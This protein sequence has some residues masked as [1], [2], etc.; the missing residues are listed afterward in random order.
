MPGM[1][2]L[3][4]APKQG[5]EKVVKSLVKETT[6]LF[7]G[8]TKDFFNPEDVISQK[9]DWVSRNS[10][11]S[12]LS[13]NRT[14]SKD[15][16]ITCAD[17]EDESSSA[18]ST[19]LALP[20]FDYFCVVGL[21]DRPETVDFVWSETSAGSTRSRSECVCHS[22]TVLHSYPPGALPDDLQR[23]I[24]SYCF[25]MGTGAYAVERSSELGEITDVVYG[26][27]YDLRS[28]A[29]F[30]FQLQTTTPDKPTPEILFG[31]CFYRK[32]FL[33]RPPRT[34]LARN[35]VNDQVEKEF[36]AI[37]DRLVA[38][39]RCY[40]MLSRV[41]LF[42]SHFELLRKILSFE[43]HFQIEE[44]AKQVD[45]GLWSLD[46][47]DHMAESASL[48]LSHD[49]QR[50]FHRR[51]VTIVGDISSSDSDDE[52]PS[53]SGKS[54]GSIASRSEKKKGTIEDDFHTPEDTPSVPLLVDDLNDTTPFF[55]AREKVKN[56]S[57]KTKRTLSRLEYSRNR[58]T[59]EDI[60]IV[61]RNLTMLVVERD[62][63]DVSTDVRK[64]TDQAS[65]EPSNSLELGSWIEADGD[66]LNLTGYLDDTATSRTPKQDPM[67]S[68]PF[69]QVWG[70]QHPL[71]LLERYK[72][73]DHT[74]Y[75]SENKELSSKEILVSASNLINA[76]GEHVLS[77][78]CTFMADIDFLAARELEG[79]AICVLCRALS[80]EN[81]VTYLTA[82]LLE[83]QIVVFESNIAYLSAIVLSILPL[84]I[85]FSWQSL[86][87]PIV[88]L[89]KQD[90]LEAPVPFV[91]GMLTKTWDIRAKCGNLVRVNAY[92]D[93]VKNA[94]F[95]KLPN[96]H[97]LIK[98]LEEPHSKI[99]R[100]GMQYGA[101]AQPIY[102]ISP[103]ERDLATSFASTVRHHLMSLTSDMAGYMITDVGQGGSS[104]NQACSVLMRETFV[105]SFDDGHKPFVD[106]WTQTQ[107]FDAYADWISYN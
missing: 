98:S 29:S 32:E 28:D 96:A 101:D 95:P 67:D 86:L 36:G 102:E 87:L 106:E 21:E 81:I 54:E 84:L 2:K 99:R 9:R 59:D 91:I 19:A 44:Y 22:S 64:D 11:F 27:H 46:R 13:N 69:N 4:T 72:K 82:V 65:G 68:A 38:S 62:R 78:K 70:N 24:P 37:P 79:W 26:Q 103:E 75:W 33:H 43:R 42:G 66:S 12:S 14:E 58:R 23:E 17:Q 52:I 92:K 25:P 97:R 10:A 41:P 60:E 105:E 83:R 71:S 35:G 20:M 76:R 3:S 77:M 1:E 74:V 53:I 100:L 8:G 5:L 88:P 48:S 31:V 40:C 94:H 80:V 51:S 89:D 7:S 55:T 16:R 56:K 18:A 15:S 104:T 107:L 50:P 85:P 73:R 30:V 6:K 61:R 47:Q 63:H 39:S 49:S 34:F 90:L 57:V 45:D 93:D